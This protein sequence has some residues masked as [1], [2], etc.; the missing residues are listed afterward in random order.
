MK[1]SYERYQP[2]LFI[3]SS[4]DWTIRQF[5]Q[6]VKDS[7]I[8]DVGAGS[9]FASRTLKPLGFKN[10]DAV[11]I[12]PATRVE[13]AK[14]YDRVEDSLEKYEFN[15]FDVALCLDVL[16]HTVNPEEFLKEVLARVK[17]GGVVFISV[18][19]ITHWSVRI[20]LLFGRFEYSDRGILDRTHL[21]FI[22]RKRL[23]KM[24][25]TYNLKTLNEDST[26]EPIELLLPSYAYQNSIYRIISIVRLSLARFWP[27]LMAFQHLAI[28]QKPKRE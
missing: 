21:Q 13:L 28:A 26:I 14:L 5:D 25:V 27:S 10:F 17:P 7:K 19:N 2:K 3:G 11:E 24:F 8:L 22:T 4:H 9:G 16:E 1:V 23:R 18:P 15:Q 20:Q 12:D 6:I